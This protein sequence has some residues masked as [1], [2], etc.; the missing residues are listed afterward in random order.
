MKTSFLPIALAA[1][2]GATIASPPLHGQADGDVVINGR[3]VSAGDLA[4][5]KRLH[6][7]PASAPVPPGRYWYDDVSGLWGPEGGPTAGQL[8]PGLGLG[9]P[10]RSDASHGDTGIF[11]NGRQIHGL[12]AAYLRG[13]FGFVIPGRYWMDWQGIGGVEG[14][15]PFF[16]LRAAART[17]GVSGGG[18]EGYTRRTPFGGIGGDGNCSYYLGSG[19]ASVLT[20]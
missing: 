14:G 10:L 13:L 2:S 15:P 4:A 1:L 7:V 11:I 5:V 20:C 3:A 17:A 12:E 16:D 18:Y 9:G 8:L 6:G 19:G